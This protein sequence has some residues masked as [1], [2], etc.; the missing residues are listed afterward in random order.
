MDGVTEVSW[1]FMA[2]GYASGKE[3]ADFAAISLV[4]D[5][6]NHAV[7]TH[8]EMQNSLV[9]LLEKNLIL[10]Q[11][12]KYSLSKSGQLLLEDAREGQKTLFAV[13]E[14]LKNEFKKI[15]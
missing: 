5:G 6:I 15:I 3:P 1:I 8:K 2:V 4:A 12:K 7:P 9:L 14:I 13:W 11:G 10:K